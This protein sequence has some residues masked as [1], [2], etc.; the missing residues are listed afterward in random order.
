MAEGGPLH[1]P[2]PTPFMQFPR[3][4]LMP[5][6]TWIFIFESY[7]D[8]IKAEREAAMENKIKNSLLFALLCF[9]GVSVLGESLY[10]ALFES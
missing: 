5:Y 2:Q 6:P 9:R 1:I 10:A 8:L 4:P 7:I 3:D